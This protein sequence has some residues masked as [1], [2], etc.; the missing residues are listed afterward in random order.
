MKAKIAKMVFSDV[1]KPIRVFTNLPSNLGSVVEKY[2]L[3][4]IIPILCA[5]VGNY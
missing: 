2:L 4:G 3:K 1:E 5:K